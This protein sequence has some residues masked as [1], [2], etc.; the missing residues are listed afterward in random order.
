MRISKSGNAL[1]TALFY[2]VHRFHPHHPHR[3]QSRFRLKGNAP[4]DD[5]FLGFHQSR[6]STTN[7]VIAGF[8]MNSL[9]PIRKIR[10]KCPIG[11]LKTEVTCYV[12]NDPSYN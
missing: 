5:G 10:L 4:V 2:K 6:L 12:S 8:N 7:T 11:N 9:T 3:S 1:P